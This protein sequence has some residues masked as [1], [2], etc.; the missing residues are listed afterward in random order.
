MIDDYYA[1]SMENVDAGFAQSSS[2]AGEACKLMAKASSAYSKAKIL[3]SADKDVW[4]A[5]KAKVT[6]GEFVSS[7]SEVGACAVGSSCEEEVSAFSLDFGIGITV[8]F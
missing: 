1:V 5:D 4:D 6:G 2:P 3:G 8:D 7:D